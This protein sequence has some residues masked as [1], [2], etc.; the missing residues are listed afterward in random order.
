MGLQ[1]CA[2]FEQKNTGKNRDWSSYLGLNEKKTLHVLK[3]Y[4][5]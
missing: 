4:I 2:I 3:S 5:S 1:G